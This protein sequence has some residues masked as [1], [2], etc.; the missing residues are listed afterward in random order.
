VGLAQEVITRDSLLDY[1]MLT[2][3]QKSSCMSTTIRAGLK[4]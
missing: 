4:L 2:G 1:R 3:G